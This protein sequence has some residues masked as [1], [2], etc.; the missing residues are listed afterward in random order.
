MNK[1]V[2]AGV[3]AG[4]VLLAGCADMAGNHA[5]MAAQETRA[6]V[7]SRAEALAVI[8]KVNGYWQGRTPA[9]ETSFWNVATYHT[10]NMAAYEVTHNE[11]YRQYSERWAEYNGWKGAKSDD[12]A[13]WKLTYGET[14]DHVLFGDWQVCFQTYL[15]LYRL[16]PQDPRAG[17]PAR[18]R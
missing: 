1:R 5:A 8:A 18:A 4:G 15:D 17:S 14:D 9:T 10:G 6:A 7:P 16:G 2:M 13:E 12:K 3:L 11:A